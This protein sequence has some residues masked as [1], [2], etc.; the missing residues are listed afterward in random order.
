[1]SGSEGFVWF[2]KRGPKGEREVE[3]EFEDVEITWKEKQGTFHVITEQTYQPRKVE[4]T[5]VQ[6][7]PVNA[8]GPMKKDDF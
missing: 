5:H 3:I 6:F 2:R 8:H 1:M 4:G 7:E